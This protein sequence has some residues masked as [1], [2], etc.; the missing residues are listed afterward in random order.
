MHDDA[1][2]ATP[3]WLWSKPSPIHLS[4]KYWVYAWQNIWCL[5]LVN[6]QIFDVNKLVFFVNTAVYAGIRLISFEEVTS[7]IEMNCIQYGAYSRQNQT[8]RSSL[9]SSKCQRSF[10]GK[11]AI[12]TQCQF[13]NA[14]KCTIVAWCSFWS[15]ATW[16]S[17]NQSY[18][19]IYR[20]I[21]QS[22]RITSKMCTVFQP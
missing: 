7:R 18:V 5:A 14:Q 16:T 11:V 6:L 2:N 9:V 19:D 1:F 21:I 22:L 4:S 13:T 17:R 12:D 3:I 8:M 20:H 10:C 15:L